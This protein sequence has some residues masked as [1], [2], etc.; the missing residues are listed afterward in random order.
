M[1]VINS[2]TNFDF[3]GR[4]NIAMALS[5][6][7]IIVSISSLAIKGLNFGVDFTGGLLLE[8]GY[9]QPADLG[10]IRE[11]LEES[12]FEGAQAQHFGNTSDVLIRMLPRP[13]VET[14]QLGQQILTLLKAGDVAVELRRVEYVGPQVGEELTERGGTAMIFAILMIM[15]YIMFRFQ[16]KFALGSVAALVHDVVIVVGVFSL[17]QLPFDLSVLAAV[18]AVIG[19]S[20]NDTIVVFDR[21]RENFRLIRRGTSAAIMNTSINQML[22]RT[23]IT[24]LT[25][26]LVVMSLFFLGGEVVSGFSSALMVGIV[27]GTYSSIYIASTTALA[28]NVSPEDLLEQKKDDEFDSEP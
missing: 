5:A 28:L 19:Y 1:R 21:I 16:W 8:L 7:V 6:L 22:G 14:A 12:G 15:A 25:T 9:E 20:L 17:L 13:D 23:M 4:R 2:K 27:V 24:S 18:L 3:M 10:A 26:L 11:R